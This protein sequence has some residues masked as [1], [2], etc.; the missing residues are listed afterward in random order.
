V[1]KAEEV[2]ERLKFDQELLC[3]SLAYHR[4]ADG[5]GY[6]PRELVDIEAE[7]HTFP[8]VHDMI[9]SGDFVFRWN[10]RLTASGEKNDR[11]ILGYESK[12]PRGGR[13]RCT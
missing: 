9:R 8:Q 13:T 7:K 2:H 3:V 1:R 11:Y 10:A 12:A 4:F 5:Q 6:S